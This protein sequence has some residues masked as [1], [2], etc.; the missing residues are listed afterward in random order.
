MADCST[1]ESPLS[2]VL[3]GSGLADAP[4]QLGSEATTRG[5]VAESAVP[6]TTEQVRLITRR[7]VPRSSAWQS[8]GSPRPGAGG[9]LRLFATATHRAC[10]DAE[11]YATRIDDVAASWRDH[12]GR[13]RADSGADRLLSVLPGAPI[14]TVASASVL[15]D[16][17]KA[18]TTDAVNALAGAGILRQ[19]N[20]VRQRYRVFEATDVLQLFTDLERAL[21]SPTG[22][23]RDARPV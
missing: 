12:L 13:V 1:K 19:R 9:W 11:H 22:D 17:S 4:L 5:D 23:T 2:G 8:L 15:I 16:R 10:I 7:A 20:V 3:G 14:I 6:L 21:A 18:R